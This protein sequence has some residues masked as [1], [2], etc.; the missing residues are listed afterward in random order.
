MDQFGRAVS[1]GFDD[2][3]FSVG[4]VGATIGQLLGD[5]IA[6]TDQAIHQVIPAAVPSW[7]VLGA[8]VLVAAW[9]IFRR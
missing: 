3:A 7:V 4:H 2:V 1:R 8:V 9:F 6:S 5:A